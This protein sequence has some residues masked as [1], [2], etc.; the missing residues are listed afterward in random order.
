MKLLGMGFILFLVCSVLVGSLDAGAQSSRF[1]DGIEL[2]GP[3]GAKAEWPASL[4]GDIQL[5]SDFLKSENSISELLKANGIADNENSRRMFEQLNPQLRT[6]SKRLS[7]GTKF[8]IISP[9]EAAFQTFK[10]GKF[11][12]K[13]DGPDA[14]QIYSRLA[15]SDAKKNKE[16]AE[17]YGISDYASLGDRSSHLKALLEI[18]KAGLMFNDNSLVRTGLEYGL[19]ADRLDYANRKARAIDR[20]VRASKVIPQD[21]LAL[22]EQAAKYLAPV[23]ANAKLTRKVKIVV[24]DGSGKAV[25]GLT[26]YSLPGQFFDDPDAYDAAY[27]RSRLLRYSFPN[28]TSP[29]VADVDGIDARVWVGPKRRYDEM[30]DMV[31]NRRLGS[32]YSV[33]NEST[34][35]KDDVEIRLSAPGDVVVLP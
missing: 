22:V 6:G 25:A 13:F 32:K 35:G 34:L 2:V 4:G 17:K 23:S 29:S 28:E 7:A 30:V 26:V 20:E 31:R 15:V 3:N 10:G 5:K 1:P 16:L 33:L 24:T 18:E 14:A 21:K 8:N 9:D 12:L 19:A 11:L 27:I